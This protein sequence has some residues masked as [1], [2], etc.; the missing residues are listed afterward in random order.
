MSA[1]EGDGEKDL[2]VQDTAPRLSVVSHTTRKAQ[3]H[4]TR[5]RRV[6][7]RGAAHTHREM[8]ASIPISC[9]SRRYR[10]PPPAEA[11]SLAT[12][13]SSVSTCTRRRRAERGCWRSKA[14][15]KAEA[16]AP[17]PVALDPAPSSTVD[18]GSSK[19]AQAPPVVVLSQTPRFA[20]WIRQLEGQLKEIAIQVART[21]T[22]DRLESGAEDMDDDE[23]MEDIERLKRQQR[24]MGTSAFEAQHI[25]EMQ[26]LGAQT[27]KLVQLIQQD[28]LPRM[29][30]DPEALFLA[31]SA[32]FITRKF[33]SA[34][35]TMQTAMMATPDGHLSPRLLAARHYFVA[36]IAIRI[37]TESDVTR[38]EDGALNAT[39]P[40]K[41]YAELCGVIE[42][43]L[44]ESLRLD[45]KL[46]S[47]YIDAEMLAQLRHP[48]D[49]H[50]RV[51]LHARMVEGA[52]QTAKYWVHK[53]QRPMHFYPKLRSQPWWDPFEFPWALKLMQNFGEIRK[54][55]MRMRRAATA[56]R[57]A[58]RWDH[59]GSKHDAGDTLLVENGDWT[60]LVLLN[61]DEKVASMV[62]RNR[63]LCPTTLRILDSIPE[64]ADMA[65]RGVGESTFSALGAGAHL[66]PHCGSTNT[67]LTCHL[68]LLAPPGSS[69]RVGDETRPCERAEGQQ[70]LES[71]EA[72]GGNGGGLGSCETPAS[73][74]SL[75][76]LSACVCARA[77]ASSCRLP[78]HCRA[79][80]G[81]GGHPRPPQGYA[82]LPCHTPLPCG[83]VIS[84]PCPAV[85]D[86]RPRGRDHDLRRL[87][88][89]P[90]MHARLAAPAPGRTTR[91]PRRPRGAA[92][93]LFAGRSRPRWLRLPMHHV[94][95]YAPCP[96]PS[97]PRHRGPSPWCV[98]V[99]RRRST[100]SGSKASLAPSALFFSSDS[101][102]P[103]SRQRATQRH[104][105][106]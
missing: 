32:E 10:A 22:G 53:L 89:A 52:C 81:R 34:L 71:R 9:T 2:D 14:A 44:S 1:L 64:A 19:E 79:T 90:C 28:L 54:E 49:A 33:E 8:Q 45:P 70:K 101:G 92:P 51:A 25:D 100:R 69:I 80:M 94:W 37:I 50:A 40:E 16:A 99:A 96:P 41:R 46:H 66:K 35:R 83:R 95:G 82:P 15:A 3:R 77:Y 18:D 7:A 13:R 98:R 42:R 11:A 87:L 55:M 104:S 36:L 23:Q 47:A 65:R 103:T 85:R 60:E 93:A 56:E 76:P 86:R 24:D 97:L 30:S 4:S 73:S 102:T 106:T 57:E 6:A 27:G 78:R 39:L 88:G 74:L 21:T 63:R 58:E 72:R 105:T 17:T 31:A 29:P 91:V 48:E 67:R 43:G 61:R 68:P 20:P 59:V 5:R 12:M 62:A 75:S 26:R 38:R 84:P